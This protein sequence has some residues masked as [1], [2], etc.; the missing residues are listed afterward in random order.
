M[1]TKITSNSRNYRYLLLVFG[2]LIAITATMGLGQQIVNDEKVEFVKFLI[3][4]IMSSGFF[5]LFKKIKKGVHHSYDKNFLYIPD[6]S[7]EEK[8]EL[9]NIFRIYRPSLQFGNVTDNWII[10]FKEP[11]NSNQ[12]IRIRISG[13]GRSFKKFRNYVDRIKKRK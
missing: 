5:F 7:L 2:G 10:E 8:T 11:V 1:R 9:T 12:N 6:G 4:L 13:Y 3:T